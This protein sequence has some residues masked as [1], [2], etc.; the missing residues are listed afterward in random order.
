M[1]QVPRADVPPI[2]IAGD[3]R[4]ARHF[5]HYFTLLGLPVQAWSRRSGPSGPV[6]AFADCQTVLLLLRDAAI[7]PFID[8]WPA[9][10]DRQLVHC[11]GSLQTPDAQSAH[12]LMTFGERL[13]DIDVYRRIPF[14]LESGDTPL[15]QLLPGLP[16]PW[17]AIPPEKKA[18][19]H[20]VCVMAG[21][22]S[23][24]LWAKLFGELEDHFAIPAS[25]A[26]PYLEQVTANLRTDR[27]RALT[28][29]LVRRD[30]ITIDRNLRALEGD[31]FHAV[32]AAFARAYAE[33]D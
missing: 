25:A 12:P 10:A 2:G 8:A 17:F 16:N 21:N 22:F 27:G 30:A 24:L 5:I 14:I 1:R 32:Y 3:G 19:Y 28:G 11:S 18:Y 7:E 33:R 15:P 9:L 23:T 6:Q 26:E 31:P 4:L 20:A 13:Y 29:P